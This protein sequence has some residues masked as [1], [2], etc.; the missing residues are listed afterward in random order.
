MK[1]QW[2]GQS[3]GHNFN[4]VGTAAATESRRG[5]TKEVPS[6]LCLLPSVT[7]VIEIAVCHHCQPVHCLNI[8]GCY[9]SQRQS[10]DDIATAAA[11]VVVCRARG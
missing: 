3:K 2:Q 1:N 9:P 10:H 6:S 7:Q 4:S 8:S 5:G 11:A